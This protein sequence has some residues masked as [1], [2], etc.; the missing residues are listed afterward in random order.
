MVVY[1]LFFQVKSPWFKA[2]LTSLS[3]HLA[4]YILSLGNTVIDW[5]KRDFLA[6]REIIK[7]RLEEVKS[8]IHISFDLWT[9]PNYLAILA[10]I[11]HYLRE[12]GR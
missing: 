5:I 6:K 12:K 4:Q 2:F 11:N 1:I 10:V 3:D 7:E 9:F 8:N